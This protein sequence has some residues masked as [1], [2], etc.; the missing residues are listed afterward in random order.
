V[1]AAVGG[2]D[3]VV[4]DPL[5]G[6]VRECEQL[7]RQHGGEVEVRRRAVE[8]ERGAVVGSGDGAE[9]LAQQLLVVGSPARPCLPCHPSCCWL[10]HR[11]CYSLT[12][13][14]G[15]SWLL[16]GSMGQGSGQEELAVVGLQGER[17]MQGMTIV[18]GK[19][20]ALSSRT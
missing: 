7:R 9:P 8:E 18:G 17:K 15:R 14:V 13:V 4:G 3:A 6:R 19:A 16:L 5:D 2:H 1:A 12:A 11:R 20:V 10:L